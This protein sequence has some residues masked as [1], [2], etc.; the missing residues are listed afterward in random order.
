M[1]EGRMTEVKYD[2]ADDYVTKI[3][4]TIISMA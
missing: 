3:I 4:A 2:L 1:E